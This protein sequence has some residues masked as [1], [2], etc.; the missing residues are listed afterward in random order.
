[1][2]GLHVLRWRNDWFDGIHQIRD[3]ILEVRSDILYL[4]KVIKK[5]L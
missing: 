3:W 4:F 1:M 5:T 2:E